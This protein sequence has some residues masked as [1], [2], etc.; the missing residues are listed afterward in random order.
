M[1]KNYQLPL[2][3]LPYDLETKL[4]LKQLNQ[5][6]KKLA[7]L[8]GVARTIPNEN[9]LISTLTLQE[10]KDSSEVENIITTQDDLYKADLGIKENLINASTRGS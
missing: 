6:N 7:E 3:P 4:I 1:N 8:K 10:A 5:A 9:I 2:L